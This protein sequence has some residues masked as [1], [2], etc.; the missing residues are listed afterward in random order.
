MA[1]FYATMKGA[2]GA[3]SRLGSRASGMSVSVKSYEGEVNVH[4]SHR[5]G[6]DYAY[7]TLGEHSGGVRVVLYNGPC[8]GWAKRPAQADILASAVWDM[9]HGREPDIAA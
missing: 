3:A 9:A 5:D 2:R 4:L 8:S 6:V 7:V 1:Q